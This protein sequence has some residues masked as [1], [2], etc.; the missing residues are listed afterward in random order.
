M[1]Q[2]KNNTNLIIGILI[3]AIIVIIATAV[4]SILLIDSA[5]EDKSDSA[6]ANKT[7]EESENIDDDDINK[8]DYNDKDYNDDTEEDIVKLR[9]A[10]NVYVQWLSSSDYTSSY[11]AFVVDW[12]CTETA[13]GTY[14]AVHNWD[15]GY[16][17][18]QDRGYDHVILMSLWN[19]PDGT[20]PE[21]EYYSDPFDYGDFSHEGSGA[22][23]FTPYDW[24][25]G[26]WY[27]M[28]IEITYEDDKTI[29][30][31]Y[32]REDGGEWLRTAALSYPTYV[33]VTWPTHVFQEDY[34]FNDLPRSCK[35]RNASGRFAN[36]NKWEDWNEFTISSSYYPYDEDPE[37]G[38]S[39]V[40]FGC[41]YKIY[42]DAVEIFS[43]GRGDKPNGKEMPY[44]GRIN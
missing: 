23:V 1:E 11:D 7:V 27:S 10:P 8:N 32:V 3:I 2:K 12:M 39:D 16:A 33:E 30:T 6:K 9:H 25:V 24:E 20:E 41:D 43:G 37:N 28:K 44:E 26:V 35:L 5:N 17:G 14:W 18:F 19:L 40:D 38:V 31:Q 34:N 42:D 22:Y 13:E 29:F 36:T 15:G 4:I 21:V